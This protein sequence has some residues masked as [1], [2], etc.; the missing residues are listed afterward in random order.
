MAS[1]PKKP[2]GPLL[3]AG[4]DADIFEYRPGLV[5][6]RSREGRSMVN[7]ARTMA[8]LHE[9]GYPVPAVEEL[10]DDG[11]ELVME[12]IEGRSMV[13]AIAAAPWSVRRQARTLAD[14]HSQLHDIAAPDFLPFAPVGSG[15][16]ILHMDL[17]P[18]NVM[19]APKGAVV[20][21]WTGAAAGDPLIDVGV[22]WVLMAAGQIPGAS[23]MATLLGWGRA[24]L[25]NGFVS[26]FDRNA[27]TSR[28]RAV[29]EWKVT[30][31]HMSQAEVAA[32]WKVVE[33]AEARA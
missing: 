25:V 7:E 30:D 6:R 2:P 19:I 11:S 33:K 12:R 13:D 1:A 20:I 21:D 23:L 5:L 9:Q 15:N 8:Y 24:L 29:V 16:R 14:L 32:M 17:H 4:R 28:L 18:L 27:V 31:P 26:R 3:A 10:S 22:A